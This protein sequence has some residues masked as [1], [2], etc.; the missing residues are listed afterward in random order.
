MALLAVME[1]GTGPVDT[2]AEIRA[3][4]T[5]ANIGFEVLTPRPGGE[6]DDPFLPHDD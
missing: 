6:Y 4:L 2:I 5:T 1:A 3:R